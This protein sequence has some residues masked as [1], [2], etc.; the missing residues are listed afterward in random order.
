MQSEGIDPVSEV[1]SS[2]DDAIVKLNPRWADVPLP[3]VHDVFVGYPIASQEMAWVDVSRLRLSIAKMDQRNVYLNN[4]V[5]ALTIE[6]QACAAAR[7]NA[8]IENYRHRNINTAQT[9][10][11]YRNWNLHPE[12][13]GLDA[14]Q[15][16]DAYVCAAMQHHTGSNELL[17][18]LLDDNPN[19]QQATH[20]QNTHM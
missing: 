12:W 9:H 2:I 14:F 16:M 17:Q 18:S 5:A 4:T 3:R 20:H 8:R 7:D 11:V 15:A 6:L 13:N 19:L 10:F 1:M